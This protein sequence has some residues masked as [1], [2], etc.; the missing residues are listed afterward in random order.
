MNIE[1]TLA[2]TNKGTERRRHGLSNEAARARLRQYGQNALPER[3]PT[4]LWRRFVKQFQ[5]PLIYILLFALAADG[6]IWLSEGAT[7]LPIE[8]IAI[9][10]ILA[11]NA[12]LGVYQESKSEA[13]LARLKE[14][15]APMVW[16]MREGRLVHLPSAELVPGDLVRVEAGDRI[17]A[18]GAL[19]EAEGVMID[20]AALTGES[21]PVDKELSGEVL[22]GT[23]LV[24]GRG[25]VEISRTGETSAMGRLAVMIGGIEAERT[26]LERRLEKFGG[27]IAR[28]VLALAA[29]IAV[30]GLLMEGIERLGHVFL[31]A[32]ALAVAAVPEGLPAVLTLTLAL[33]VE[34]M[35]KRKAIVRRLSAVEALGSVTV[36]ATDKTGTLTEN[37][38]FVRDLDSLDPER[39]L[40]AM[41]LA[42]DADEKVGAGDPLEL[43]LLE[44]SMRRGVDLDSLRNRRPRHSSLPFDS[45]YKYM[46]ATVEES[47]ALVSYLKGAPE[48]ILQRASLSIEERRNWEEKADGY[49]REGFRVLAFGSREGESDEDIEF[50]GLAL[51]WDPPRP[52]VPD[53]ISRAQEAGIRVVMVT[54]DHPATALAVASEV[55]IPPS[56]VLTGLE[57]ETLPAEALREA[58]RETNIFARVAPEHKLRLVEALK[59][60]GEI[61][62][63]TGDGVNDAPALKRSDVGVA[64]GER[65]SDVSREVADLVLMDDNF[66]TIVAAIEEGRNIYENIQKFI[67]F[68]FSTNLAEVLI[69][70]GGAFG[71]ALMGLRDETGAIL[72]PLTAVQLLWV[73]I[74]TDGPPA[75]ALGLDRDPGV[76]RERPRDPRAPLLDRESLRFVLTTGCAKTAIA[77]AL[78]VAAPLVGFSLMQTRTAIFLHTTIGQLFYA[79]PSRRIN[80]PPRFNGAL[81]LAVIL[82]VAL[83]L[84][85]VLLPSL[86]ALLG[87]EPLTLEILTLVTAAVSLTWGS[88]E[89]YSRLA[90]STHHHQ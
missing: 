52:E 35:A 43:A 84:L 72:L 76:M 82:G 42:N 17:P 85:T 87:L 79:Y 66:S 45:S 88:A 55:G 18:D 64:M 71:A 23:L 89:A 59:Q 77:G 25:Y 53:A 8:S 1:D 24:R 13:A 3:P 39:A 28:G 48:V 10:V 83:Q 80:A 40:R 68:L 7:G 32:V 4:P 29:L 61:V 26:P 41:A 9:A 58:V 5:S 31:F 73:N 56:R 54:G 37:R 46:R 57:L 2:E 6:A 34:R 78:M 30:A 20:E 44:Y 62:A 21:I 38:M 86:R 90:L 69:V 65:G 33:G 36:I 60:N 70:V 19:I 63:M 75:L 14:M 16:V 81:H 67:R 12:G 74:V 27:Q 15:A 50:L 49:A 51:L 11:L 47:G 22:S